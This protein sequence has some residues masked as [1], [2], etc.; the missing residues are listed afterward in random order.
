[1][2]LWMNMVAQA[3]L[4]AGEILNVVAPFMTEHQKMVVTAI[5][6]VCSIVVS[7]LSHFY[8]TDGTPQQAPFIKQ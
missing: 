5:L 8:N 7:R 6:A 1:M 4:G 3:I 2:T